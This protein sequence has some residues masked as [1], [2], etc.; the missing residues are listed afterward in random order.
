MPFTDFWDRWRR[1]LQEQHRESTPSLGQA[2]KQRE[3]AE[4]Q[5]I[6]EPAKIAAEE[7]DARAAG[8]G[9]SHDPGSSGDG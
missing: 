2:E 7:R 8:R 6:Q 3:A 5:A 9:H 1:R 4:R